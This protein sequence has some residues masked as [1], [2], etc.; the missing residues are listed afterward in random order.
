[1]DDSTGEMRSKCRWQNG[2]HEFLELKHNLPIGKDGFTSV[3]YSNHRF[4]TDYKTLYGLTGTLGSIYTRNFLSKVFK[5]DTIF[6]FTFMTSRFDQLKPVLCD[7]K[8]KWNDEVVEKII[9]V[10]RTKRPVL[11]I[12]ETIEDVQSIHTILELQHIKNIHIVEYIDSED[13]NLSKLLDGVSCNTVILA[14]NLAGRGTDVIISKEIDANG[15]LFVILGFLPISLR[16]LEQAFGRASRQGQNGSGMLITLK[17]FYGATIEYLEKVRSERER[18]MMEVTAMEVIDS[19]ITKDKMFKRVCE[20]INS[21]ASIRTYKGKLE[22]IK[23]LWGEFYCTLEIKNP[24]LNEQSYL[25][26]S[27]MCT[28]E[29]NFRRG[30][31]SSNHMHYYLSAETYLKKDG[32]NMGAAMK[33]LKKNTTRK[34]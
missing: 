28:L 2:L 25:F 23:E 21:D 24:P 31:F 20:F 8:N 7:D 12:L 11:A 32:F 14:T 16:N 33:E 29:E 17:S 26:E 10:N 27:F 5:L 19:Y 13:E 6:V 9:T 15:G 3:Y 18:I 4:F 1:V 22:G 30:Q 34:C